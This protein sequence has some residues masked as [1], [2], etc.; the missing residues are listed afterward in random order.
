LVRRRT[1][2]TW[3]LR[4]GVVKPALLN[5]AMQRQSECMALCAPAARRMMQVL[6]PYISGMKSGYTQAKICGRLAKE[7]REQ[8][9]ADYCA[10]T[11]LELQQEYPLDRLLQ[12]GYRMEQDADRIRIMIPMPEGRG[13]RGAGKLITGIRYSAVMICGDLLEGQVPQVQ[14]AISPVYPPGGG[15]GICRLTLALPQDGGAWLLWLKAACMEGGE[16][17]LHPKWKGM[18]AVGWG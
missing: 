7:L 8:G 2:D 5:S 6:R 1:G 10:L 12:G 16:E 3:R 14:E 15:A 4:R 9:F 18:K 11:G 13:I 17:A